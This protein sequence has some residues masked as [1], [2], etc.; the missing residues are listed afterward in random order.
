MR[1]LRFNFSMW[2]RKGKARN[3]HSVAI[4]NGLEFTI[5]AFFAAWTHVI[6][7]NKKHFNKASAKI[8]K[9]RAFIFDFH[10]IGHF[11]RAARLNFSIHLDAANATGSGGF[12]TFE[13]TKGW[14]VHTSS[15]AASTIL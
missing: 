14:H 7:F 9:F 5:A 12:Q 11:C 8:Y 10:S 1:K 15:R 13:I 4:G 2:K 6:A 3:T